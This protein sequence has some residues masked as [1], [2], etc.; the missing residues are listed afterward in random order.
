MV[1]RYTMMK[2]RKFLGRKTSV[3]KALCRKIACEGK[4]TPRG[5]NILNSR[6]KGELRRDKGCPK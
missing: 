3:R 5:G 4:G 1:Q 6:T 2:E